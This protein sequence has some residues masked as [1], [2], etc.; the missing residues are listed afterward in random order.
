MQSRNLI[1][2]GGTF[3]QPATI[4][5]YRLPVFSY[6]FPQEH[7]LEHFPAFAVRPATA[8]LAGPYVKTPIRR[9]PVFPVRKSFMC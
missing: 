2:R 6:A 1:R 3:A 4:M 8:P 9:R 5:P 7:V